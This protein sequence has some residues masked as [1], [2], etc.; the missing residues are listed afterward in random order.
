MISKRT[1]SRLMVS[2]LIMSRRSKGA[3][4][5]AALLCKSDNAPMGY[6][7]GRMCESDNIFQYVQIRHVQIR[8][9]F[10]GKTPSSAP[11]EQVAA[12]PW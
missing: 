7:L 6:V 2:G 12:S 1:I 11:Q 8:Q 3:K 5:P 10:S 4:A 9:G